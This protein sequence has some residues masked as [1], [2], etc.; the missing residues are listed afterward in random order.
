M[1]AQEFPGKWTA[2]K[3]EALTTQQRFAL[4]EN[5]KNAAGNLNCEQSGFTGAI[6]ESG[7]IVDQTAMKADNPVLRRM[8]EVIN[9][10]I[11]HAKCVEATANGLP[12]LAGIEPEIVD[13]LGDLYRTSYMATVEAGGF[14]GRLMR[15]LNYE[16]SGRK[17]MPD[18]S[19]EKTAAVWRK[20]T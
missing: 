20:K 4:L 12:A 9:S 8:Y 15:D 16:R 1:T 5:V 17:A 2:A 13:E 7:P 18:G 6:I 19:I 10:A 11:G 3:L 14:V